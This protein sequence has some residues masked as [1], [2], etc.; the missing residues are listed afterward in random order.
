MPEPTAAPVITQQRVEVVQ[1]IN[2]PRP[3]VAALTPFALTGEPETDKGFTTPSGSKLRIRMVPM[4]T[5]PAFALPGSPIPASSRAVAMRL[6]VSLLAADGTVQKDSTGAFII[7]PPHELY[8]QPGLM[9]EG[10]NIAQV[11]EL[12]LRK[13]AYQLE[14]QVAQQKAI[15]T[16]LGANWA[17]SL[18]KAVVQTPARTAAPIAPLP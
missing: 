3:A 15:A 5:P 16:Y 6:S 1:V 17:G 13:L 11:I 10:V 18:S 14:V 7:S 8:L 4:E 9:V 12:E 2:E